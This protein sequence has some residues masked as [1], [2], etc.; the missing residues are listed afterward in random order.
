MLLQS[1]DVQVV[2]ESFEHWLFVK[3]SSRLTHTNYAADLR[4]F[5]RWYEAST[6]PFLPENL[7]TYD[8][9]Q[10]R[11]HSIHVEGVKPATWNRRKASLTMYIKYLLAHGLPSTVAMMDVDRAEE[12][13]RSPRWLTSQEFG[14][15]ARWME[16]AETMANT[17]KRKAAARRDVAMLALMEFAGLREFEVLGLRLKNIR[18][19]ERGG[20]FQFYGKREKFAD[21]DI[22][23]MLSKPLAA[24]LQA[25]PADSGPETILFDLS[26]R[27]LQKR[28][29]EIGRIC[30]IDGLT[31]H[32]FRHDYCKR[33]QIA[34][35]P[36]ATAMMASR[37][38][39][40]ET[41][42]RYQMPGREELLAA[43]EAA[44]MASLP[45][46]A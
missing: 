23:T 42:R 46:E 37:H 26:A 8:I 30:Q 22:V 32:R 11:F 13:E 28:V 45:K 31:P 38:S 12:A 41:L 21:L 36:E 6:G 29:T 20:K 24:F 35:I 40:P 9:Q 5:T 19:T 44:S 16:R 27:A 10:Y 2:D 15:L 33:F 7:T 34:R 17:P 39:N 1:A 3:G 14:R 18:L 4:K 43:M 25:L